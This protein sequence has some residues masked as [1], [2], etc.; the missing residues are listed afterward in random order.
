MRAQLDTPNPRSTK[1]L[2]P[3]TSTAF[4]T[5][6]PALPPVTTKSLSRSQ[7]QEDDDL[8]FEMLK[9]NDPSSYGA[10][11]ATSKGYQ[12]DPDEELTATASAGGKTKYLKIK[13]FAKK[14]DDAH[15]DDDDDEMT[16][17]GSD[18]RSLVI[19]GHKS[20]HLKSKVTVAMW[21]SANIRI[22]NE[23]KKKPNFSEEKYLKYTSQV[24][25]LLQVYKPAD[26]VMAYDDL[27]RRNIATGEIKEWGDPFQHGVTVCLLKRPDDKSYND[28][29][30]L[31]YNFPRGCSRVKCNFRHV[32]NVEG[33]GRFHPHYQH[34]NLGKKFDKK[35]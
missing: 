28:K 1:N 35:E 33:C 26:K 34:P 22:M 21:I 32:C 7:K 2:A 5:G 14:I 15:D 3:N 27:Y 30:C 24:G 12:Y 13:D 4:P 10:G 11:G 19:K 9:Q 8:L 25:D 29:I 16:V 20:S 31:D 18:G 17:Q 23:L 6:A